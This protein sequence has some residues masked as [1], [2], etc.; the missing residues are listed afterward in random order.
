MSA[1]PQVEITE[2]EAVIV[3]IRGEVSAQ[4]L[5]SR[6]LDLGYFDGPFETAPWP[7]MLAAL[8]KFQRDRGLPVTGYPDR[9]TIT[10]LRE[11]Y[12]F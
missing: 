3:L 1:D 7:E 11:S 9:D 8:K 12:C 4:E 5:Q 10:M 6:L 2:T